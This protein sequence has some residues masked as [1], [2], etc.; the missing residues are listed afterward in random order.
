MAGAPN[1]TGRGTIPG[2]T[3]D[4]LTWSVE[5]IAA[6]LNDGFAPDF[7]TAGGQMAD[8]VLNMANLTSE[9]RLAIAAYLK[10]LPVPE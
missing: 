9:D 1:P 10:V 6:Y 2:L 5:E 4:D 3:P 8:V 7:D